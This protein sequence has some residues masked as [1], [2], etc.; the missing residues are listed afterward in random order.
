MADGQQTHEDIP[1]DTPIFPDDQLVSGS[2]ESLIEDVDVPDEVGDPDA[3][4]QHDDEE[5]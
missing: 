2:E 3:D 5:A 1:D 4:A